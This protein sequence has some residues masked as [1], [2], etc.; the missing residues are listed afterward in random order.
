[1]VHPVPLL[2][3]PSRSRPSPAVGIPN[4]LPRGHDSPFSQWPPATGLKVCPGVTARRIIMKASVFVGTS[5]DGFIARPNG[6]LDFLT[7]GP[8]ED[9]GYDAFLETVDAV[10][11]GRK[12]FETVLTYTAWPYGKRL[13]VVLSNTLH[14]LDAPAAAVCELMRGSPAQVWARLLARGVQHVYVDGGETIQQFLREGLIDTL[15]IN[16]Y[17]VLIG[18]G[19]PLFG[20]LIRDI[21]L[22]HVATRSFPS[23]FVKSEYRVVPEPSRVS[24]PGA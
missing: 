24:G 17:P 3:A 6:S 4:L 2:D 16:R 8:D 11:I 5:L 15:V 20:S 9:N 7:I 18:S 14:T 12:T 1:M 22:Q 13:V 23:G 10:V 21:R 19:V